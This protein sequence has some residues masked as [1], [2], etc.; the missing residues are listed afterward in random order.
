MRL[1][2]E[3]MAAAGAGGV[4][5]WRGTA[6]GGAGAEG[7]DGDV[8]IRRRAFL[9]FAAGDGGDLREDDAHRRRTEITYDELVDLR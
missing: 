7:G 8:A 3:G 4:V 6:R 1:A 9:R 5:S 2:T